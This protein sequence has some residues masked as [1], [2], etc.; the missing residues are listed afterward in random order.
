MLEGV[1]VFCQSSIKIEKGKIIYFDPYKIEKDYN[2]ADYIFITHDHFDHYDENSIKKVMKDSSYI[3]VPTTLVDEVINIFD[4]NRIIE[5]IPNKDYVVDGLEFTTVSAY[6]INKKFH[7]KENGWVGYVINLN[8]VK[9]YAMGD[10]DD[11]P[12][13]R[14]VICDVLF[15][16][17]GGTYT[18]N[19]NEAVN[20]VNF[21]KPKIAVPIHYK[22]VVGTFDDALYFINHLDENIDG[23]ILMN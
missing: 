11:I 20:F 14:E 4:S 17:V 5:V 3:V 10:T 18:M 23:K 1:N 2:D 7:P 15:I 21:I 13:A 16:P 19:S 8:E 6:N 22:T 9:Y 12:E